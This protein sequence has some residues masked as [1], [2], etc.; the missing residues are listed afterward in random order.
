[1]EEDY[2]NIIIDNGSYYIKAGLSGEEQPRTIFRS[3]IGYPKNKDCE[4]NFLVG[5]DAEAKSDRLNISYPI[6]YGAVKNWDEMEKIWKHTFINELAIDP[7]GHNIMLTTL[8]FS[9]KEYNEKSIEIMFEN[10]NVN[11][12]Y[13]E[14][15]GALSL[16]CFGKV[17]G[18]S[19]DLGDM[20]SNFIPIIDG[21]YILYNIT[22]FDIGGRDLTEFI[23]KLII[24]K[25]LK[26][27]TNVQREIIKDIKEKACYA[28][29][30]FE[31]ELNFVDPFNYEMPDGEIL[32]IKDQRIICAEALFKS[33]MIGKEDFN[34]SQ[35]CYDSI[36]KYDYKEQKDFYNSIV[37]SGGT[38][39]F[40]GF[41]ER[42]KREIKN[43]APES[44]KEEVNVIAF[45]ERKCSAV[46]GGSIMSSLES[47]KDMW[48]T[49]DEY[50]ESG[51]AII[52]KKCI[53]TL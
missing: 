17:S 25:I 53:K 35:I 40:K 22:R 10:F 46:I 11:G 28:A 3:L 9:P 32:T 4:I 29:F 19:I 47:F 26:L 5:C 14:Y 39:M 34:I 12:F 41:P 30:V 16:Y 24:E 1:M 21:K 23:K 48:I 49:K 7:E 13:M 20:V 2:H 44:L 52:Y 15:P 42:L 38:S 50:E 45:P 8:P 6:E 37:L 31:D 51:A 33:S 27:S 43:L 36:K 18:L